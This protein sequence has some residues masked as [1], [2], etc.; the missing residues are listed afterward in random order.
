[1]YCFGCDSK[2]FYV[3]ICYIFFANITDVIFNHMSQMYLVRY[4]EKYR[5]HLMPPELSRIA[6]TGHIIPAFVHKQNLSKQM[7]L[8]KLET[9]LG[10]QNCLEWSWSIWNRIS[11]WD[12][13]LSQSCKHTH[14]N[15]SLTFSNEIIY[16]SYHLLCFIFMH[17]QVFYQSILTCLLTQKGWKWFWLACFP[18]CSN[19]AGQVILSPLKSSIFLFSMKL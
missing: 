9:D 6:L 19:C 17:L 15:F 10:L 8:I 16:V 4:H 11:K 3:N 1:M 7:A 12:F 13:V 5:T 14:L 18:D 2:S